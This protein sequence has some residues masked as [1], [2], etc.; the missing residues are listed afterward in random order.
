VLEDS[1]RR[2]ATARAMAAQ[3]DLRLNTPTGPFTQ[4]QI[5]QAP[6]PG[7]PPPGSSAFD[8]GPGD[9]TNDD[10]D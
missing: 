9:Q 8:F 2:L 6:A 4:R 5:V 1:P 10:K 7:R 3:V